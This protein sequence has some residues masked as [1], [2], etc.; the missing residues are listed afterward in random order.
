MWI[1]F[2]ELKINLYF[3]FMRLLLFLLP[4]LLTGCTQQ[5]DPEQLLGNYLQISD[6]GQV[7]EFDQVLAGS[8]LTAAKDANELLA[9]LG[10]EQR[11]QTRFYAFQNSSDSEFIFCLD[12]SKTKLFDEAG[13]DQTPPDRPLQVPMT[14]KI[15]TFAN[16]TKISELNIRRFESC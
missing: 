8:A 6:T 1:T 15:E 14:M 13:V 9:D 5:V 10:L 4:L 11:G 12:V 2:S 3:F 7:E 16:L